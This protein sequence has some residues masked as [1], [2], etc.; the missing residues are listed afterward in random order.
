MEQEVS[1]NIRYL[2][3]AGKLPRAKWAE[4]L[5]TW[6]KCDLR[7]AEQLLR[8]GDLRQ[9]EQRSI[10]EAIGILEE[11]LLL[12]SLLEIRGVD[13][14]RE[15]MEYLISTLNHGEQKKLAEYVGV[16]PSTISRWYGGRLRPTK[17]HLEWL[18]LYFGLPL[19]T[20]LE[21]EPIFLSLLPITVDKRKQWLIE[22]IQA[23]DASTLHA[24][25]PALERLLE[26]R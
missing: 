21:T 18:G 17:K 23:L 15:N 20:N 2:L 26:G 6:A 13:I 7:R 5:A 8:N 12:T 1:T 14:L 24:L 22:H 19:H 16:D 25:F 10:I 3:W 4:H 9:N 11:D